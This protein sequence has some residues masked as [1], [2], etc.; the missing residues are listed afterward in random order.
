MLMDAIDIIA[1]RMQFALA[2]NWDTIAPV[3]LA[4][5][6]MASHVQVR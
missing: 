3:L 5:R 4:T 2:L 6:E 1:M